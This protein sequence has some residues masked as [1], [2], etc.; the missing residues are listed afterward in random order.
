MC[1]WYPILFE[2][3][4]GFLRVCVC[5]LQYTRLPHNEFLTIYPFL[6]IFNFCLSMHSRENHVFGSSFQIEILMDLHVL[7]FPESKNHVHSGFSVCI[8][9][10]NKHNSKINKSRKFKFGILGL[11]HM[12]ILLESFYENQTNDLSWRVHKRIPILYDLW[13]KFV[14]S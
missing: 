10:Y 5:V 2:I 1:K 6:L 12:E 4:Q 11:Y 3:F 9:I 8:C 7:N 14:V 13:I